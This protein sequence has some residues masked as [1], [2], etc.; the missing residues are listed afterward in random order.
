[1]MTSYD[2]TVTSWMTQ[3]G[4]LGENNDD[5]IIKTILNDFLSLDIIKTNK[6]RGLWLL[7][8]QRFKNYRHVY[9]LSNF[10]DVIV[11]YDVTMTSR[12]R[13]CKSNRIIWE[14]LCL[15]IIEP[16]FIHPA[17]VIPFLRRGGHDGPPPRPLK[18]AKYPS[19]NRVKATWF[20]LTWWFDFSWILVWLPMRLC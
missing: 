2:V 1:M 14:F 5:V 12:W 7:C 17:S 19:L 15:S 9:M 3:I 6:M 4:E 8:N 20:W 16:S 13:H 10:D 11:I 18:I